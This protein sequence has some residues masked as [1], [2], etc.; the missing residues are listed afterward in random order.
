LSKNLL[1]IILAGMLCG[2]ST[3]NTTVGLQFDT[4]AIDRIE[5]GKTTQSEVI[6][7]LGAP[8][9]EE[10][11]DNGIVIFSY[12]YG[13]R[14]SL[15]ATNSVDSLQIQLFKGVVINKWQRLSDFE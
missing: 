15:G 6:A 4:T 9:T 5:V 11:L 13:Y 14:R 8:R 7:M 3:Y 10:K 12:A 2:C 1:I